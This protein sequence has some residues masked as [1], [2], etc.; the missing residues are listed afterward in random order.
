LASLAQNRLPA[1]DASEI[2]G[3]TNVLPLR[4]AELRCIEERLRSTIDTPA[5]DPLVAIDL[6]ICD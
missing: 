4:K 1:I 3:A 2:R 5:A 6:P